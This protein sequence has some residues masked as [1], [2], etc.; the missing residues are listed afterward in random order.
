MRKNGKNLERRE[1]LTSVFQ[2]NSHD[3]L[4][5]MFASGVVDVQDQS[6]FVPVW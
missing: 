4:A 3:Y 1:L 2:G 5:R 6:F